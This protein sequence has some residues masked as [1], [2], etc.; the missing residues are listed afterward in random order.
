LKL[1]YPATGGKV[2]VRLNDFRRVLP[3][4]PCKS[5]VGDD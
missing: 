4:N 3:F 2:T 1:A 5:R